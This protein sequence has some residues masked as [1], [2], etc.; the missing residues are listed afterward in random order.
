MCI[1]TS[2]EGKFQQ[3]HIVNVHAV[4]FIII[5]EHLCS[6][7][8]TSGFCSFG[9]AMPSFHSLVWK[10]FCQFHISTLYGKLDMVPKYL[11]GNIL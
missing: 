4:K 3:I 6:D 1:L 9:A 8:D 5:I 11:S 10:T 2:Q 7:G